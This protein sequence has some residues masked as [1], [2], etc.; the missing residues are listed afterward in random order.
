MRINGITEA[1]GGVILHAASRSAELS[2]RSVRYWM[3]LT[4][5]L[6]I[7]CRWV[8]PWTARLPMLRSAID[9]GLGLV[10]GLV[11][12]GRGVLQPS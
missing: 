4:R 7:A 11:G 10:V 8:T 1:R 9:I 6:T 3:R 2:S 12:G 5:F